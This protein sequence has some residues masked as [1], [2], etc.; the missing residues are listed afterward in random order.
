MP[1]AAPRHC[2]RRVRPPIV[3]AAI[4]LLC[5]ACNWWGERPAA[6]PQPPRIVFDDTGYEFGHVPQGTTVTHTFT[7]RNAG[8]RDLSIDSIRTSCACTVATPARIVPPGA[9]GTIHASFD[10]HDEFGDHTRTITVYSNDPAQAVT[11]L[12]LRGSIDA[13]VAA[14]PSA[15]YVGHLRRGQTALNEVR[16]I[17]T[18]PAAVTVG[19]VETKGD[20]VGSRLVD[21]P[22]GARGTRLRVTIK[23]DAPLG[24]FKDSLLVHTS[25][26]RWPVV[27][28]PVAGVVDADLPSGGEGAKD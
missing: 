10:T 9:T 12:A 21:A 3:A 22:A 27:T 11:T 15:L 13:D 4:G 20:V 26:G 6:P 14:E 24:V 2:R 17:I 5:G 18:N 7:F 1:S 19:A 16:L 25:S 8:G 28:I 23:P